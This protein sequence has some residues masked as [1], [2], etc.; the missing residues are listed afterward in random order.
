MDNNIAKNETGF[1]APAMFKRPYWS[2]YLNLK[3]NKNYRQVGLGVSNKWEEIACC[4]A[5]VSKKEWVILED[6]ATLVWDYTL[7][8]NACVTLS[9]KHTNYTLAEPTGTED[10][11]YG[12]LVIDNDGTSITTLA[13][14]ASFIV[15]NGGAGAITLTATPF[16]VDSLSWV[17]KGAQFLVTF[18]ANFT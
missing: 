4:A 3:T 7:G 17:R 5:P 15:V 18:G 10:G 6:T 16:A 8:Y 14:P 12:T 2:T 1:Q 11:D 9:A 13:L